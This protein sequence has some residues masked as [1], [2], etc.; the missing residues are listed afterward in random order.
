M[1]NVLSYMSRNVEQIISMTYV[2][3]VSCAGSIYSF[4]T[5][6]GEVSKLLLI[7]YSNTCKYLA[8]NYKMSEFYTIAIR[9]PIF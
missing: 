8:T 4:P 6:I 5:Y 7:L 1:H 3:F 2:Y 9:R